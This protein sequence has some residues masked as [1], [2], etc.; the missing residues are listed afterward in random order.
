MSAW[1]SSR[2]TSLSGL[3]VVTGKVFEDHRG[4]FAR[5]FCDEELED[6]GK[7]RQINR[8]LTRGIGDVRGLHFQHPPHAET[9]VVR[10][11]RG[12]VWDVA[13]DLRKGSP[14]FLQWHAETL[15]PENRNCL[16]IPAGFAHGFQA[17]SADCE[18]LYLHTQPYMPATED[19]LRYNDLKL[20]IPWPLTV[21]NVSERDAQFSSIDEHFEGLG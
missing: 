8:S 14:T 12:E 9:K 18:L 17:I 7:I 13:V 16:V 10:C 6:I 2:E 5:L 11:L 1:F 19:G 21:A 15:S 4:E 3:T 20:G